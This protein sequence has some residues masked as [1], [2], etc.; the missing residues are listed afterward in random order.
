MLGK[1]SIIELHPSPRDLKHQN[2]SRGHPYAA[3]SGPAP[4][5]STH[6]HHVLLLGGIP[7]SQ[8]HDKSQHHCDQGGTWESK[9]SWLE[10]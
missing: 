9:D 1:H 4:S 7:E 6:L 8:V 3:S 2:L 10:A 5:Q